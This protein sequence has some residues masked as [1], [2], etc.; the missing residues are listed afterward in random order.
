MY[1]HVHNPAE[2]AQILKGEGNDL[3]TSG[4]YELAIEKYIQ[5][6]QKA[7]DNAILYANRAACN[8]AL[9]KFDDA[10]LDATKATELDSEYAKGWK[11]GYFTSTRS[12]YAKALKL[13]KE[14]TEPRSASDEKLISTYVIA[15]KQFKALVC[16]E[17]AWFYDPDAPWN[18]AQIR[19]MSVEHSSALGKAYLAGVFTYE[20]LLKLAEETI[21][22]L[23]SRPIP[24]YIQ[25]DPV[26]TTAYY[27]YL[28]AIAYIAL[29]C[30]KLEIGRVLPENESTRQEKIRYLLEAGKGYETAGNLFHADDEQRGNECSYNEPSDGMNSAAP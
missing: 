14:K 19:T 9:K 17:H 21:V 23:D 10:L 27:T 3:Y 13:L 24:E 15:C 20:G 22:E 12:V 8:L 6:I 7:P 2:D 30:S 26:A 18:I 25:A 29:A 16:A 11:A 28:R 1:N 4:A 5:A